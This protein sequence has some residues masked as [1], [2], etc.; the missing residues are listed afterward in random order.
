MQHTKDILKRLH[1]IVPFLSVFHRLQVLVFIQL[2]KL[3]DCLYNYKT[4][5]WRATHLFA[6]VEQRKGFFKG[7]RNGAV[8]FG[9]AQSRRFHLAAEF[10]I[11]FCVFN[12]LDCK[13]ILNL[14]N[15]VIFLYRTPS[16]R[17]DERII[18]FVACGGHL[19]VWHDCG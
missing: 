5:S 15:T 13:R 6:R 2:C 10:V 16:C 3:P 1:P 17:A 11:D 12:R 19:R 18:A 8:V 7:R 14:V 9:Q 4:D